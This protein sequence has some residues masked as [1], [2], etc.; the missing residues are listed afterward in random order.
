MDKAR[1]STNY[2]RVLPPLLVAVNLNRDGGS[3]IY[4]AT[5]RVCVIAGSHAFYL[6]Q[7][8]Q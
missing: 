3:G 1:V 2:H 8:L 4:L 6:G 5:S 7:V